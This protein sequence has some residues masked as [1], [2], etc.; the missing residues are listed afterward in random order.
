MLDLLT[1]CLAVQGEAAEVAFY[2]SRPDF[3][4]FILYLFNTIYKWCFVFASSLIAFCFT[5]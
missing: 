2:T 5:L 1:C 4:N 3:V